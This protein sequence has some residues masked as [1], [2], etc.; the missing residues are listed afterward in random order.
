M[1]EFPEGLRN[2]AHNDVYEH[3]C[4]ELEQSVRLDMTTCSIDLRSPLYTALDGN[5]TN[6]LEARQLAEAVLWRLRTNYDGSNRTSYSTADH[7]F[8]FYELLYCDDRDNITPLFVAEQRSNVQDRRSSKYGEVGLVISSRPSIEHELALFPSPQSNAAKTNKM[9]AKLAQPRKLKPTD[10]P[11]RLPVPSQQSE[12]SRINKIL[13][14][15]RSIGSLYISGARSMLMPSL[16]GLKPT[17]REEEIESR[18]IADDYETHGRKRKLPHDQT[19]VFIKNNPEGKQPE[20]NDVFARLG[21]RL[22]KL[23]DKIDPTGKQ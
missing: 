13:G 3:V 10:I 19:E 15:A 23:A 2:Q 16:G 6:P 14:I 7:S 18:S 4:R 12:R 21:R 9:P 5:V 17:S 22:L 1:S 20:P 11:D 8:S